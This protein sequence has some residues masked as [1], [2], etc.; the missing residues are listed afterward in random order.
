M[1]DKRFRDWPVDQVHV[2]P[3]SVDD[4]VSDKNHL[5]LFVR[6]LVRNRPALAEI[7]GAV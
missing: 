7:K 5:A 6:D 4:Y 3:P 1:S 2:L